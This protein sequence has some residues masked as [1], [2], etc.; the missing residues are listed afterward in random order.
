MARTGNT[1]LWKCS[2]LTKNY[3]HVGIR[4]SRRVIDLSGAVEPGEIEKLK[5]NSGVRNQIEN[6]PEVNF[7][8]KVK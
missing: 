8:I 5:L 6:N 4:R 7:I 3:W 2:Q 1:I